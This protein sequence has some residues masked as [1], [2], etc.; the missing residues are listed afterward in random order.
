M[1]KFVK[2][3]QFS[4]LFFILICYITEKITSLWLAE[5]RAIFRLHLI[6]IAMQINVRAF[7]IFSV[8]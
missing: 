4:S 1:D 3:R 2:K 7:V 5:S 6:C 8:M